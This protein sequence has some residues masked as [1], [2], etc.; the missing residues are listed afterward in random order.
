M[1]RRLLLFALVA[2]VA[3]SACSSRGRAPRE[4]DAAD[5]GRLLIDRNWIDEMPQSPK[6]RLHVFR[7]VPKMGGGVYQDR[8]LF[9]GEFELFVFKAA[10][11]ELSFR[12]PDSGERYQT[13]FKIEEVDGPEPFDLRL[14]LERSPRGPRIYYGVRD[15]HGDLDASLAALTADR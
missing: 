13:T 4:V 5:A 2:G 7:F 11:R 8:T 9:R 3:G 6:D 15:E 14:T 10:K 1:T 12:F